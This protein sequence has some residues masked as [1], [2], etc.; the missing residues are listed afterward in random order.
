MISYQEAIECIDQSV[1]SISYPEKPKGLYAPIDYILNLKGKK[2]RPVLTLLACNLYKDSINDAIPS[3]LAWEVFHNF[4]LMHDDLMDHADIRRSQ[5]TVHKVWDANTAILSGD[6]MLIL[7]YQYMTNSPSGK[8]KELLD[9]FSTTAMEI[10]EGQQYD[11][12][13][14]QR[15]DVSEAEYLEMIRLKT[16]V[17]IGA[18]LKSGGII[19]GANQEDVQ[20]LYDFGINFGLAFQ[21]R[22]DLLDVYG[23]SEI[24]GKN[25]GGDI[26]CNKKTYLLIRAFEMATGSLKQELEQWINAAKYDPQEK[27]RAVTAIY[28]QLN[29]RM[30]CEEKMDSFYSKALRSFDSVSVSADKKKILLDLIRL[31]MK[32][33]V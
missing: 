21:I 3:A 31:M 19:G 2:I 12:D 30:L 23:T 26:L 14:E 20:H 16:A 18:C 1:S 13:F 24:F 4:T 10:C 17:M 25:I 29:I 9:L 11:M 32:R 6:A 5:P 27:I 15:L 8:V 28:D 33:T 22:D 7:A